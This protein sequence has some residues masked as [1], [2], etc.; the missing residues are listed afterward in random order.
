[1]NTEDVVYTHTQTMEYFAPTGKK[2][3]M[4]LQQH[5]WT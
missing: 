3:M 5:G 1:M 2:E 4:L